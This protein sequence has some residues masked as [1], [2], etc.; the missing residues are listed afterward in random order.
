MALLAWL[1]LGGAIGWFASQ[2]FRREEGSGPPLQVAI[3]SI[4]GLTGGAFL[5]A[6]GPSL[7]QALSWSGLLF[8]VLGAIAFVALERF[9]RN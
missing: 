3:G 9:G 1:L 6:G 5:G 8:A 7:G 4:G 2:R